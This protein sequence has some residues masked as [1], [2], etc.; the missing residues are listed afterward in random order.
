MNFP[1]RLAAELMLGF[2]P[3]LLSRVAPSASAKYISPTRLAFAKSGASHQSDV[4]RVLEGLADPGTKVLSQVKIQT[5]N[6]RSNYF[7]ADYLVQIRG[8]WH[9]FDAKG[10]TKSR[11]PAQTLKVPDFEKSGGIAHKPGDLPKEGVRLEPSR[12][13][14]IT[15]EM[16]E[17]LRNLGAR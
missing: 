1:I 14:E 9:V 12:V 7:T 10:A 15:P 11:T 4:G 8:R 13:R 2:G 17:R 5:G 3:S 6:W 16:L